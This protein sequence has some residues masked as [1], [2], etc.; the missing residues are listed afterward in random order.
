MGVA[1]IKTATLFYKPHSKVIPNF[2]GAQTNAWIIFPYDA[3]KMI[4]VLGKK[5]F[6][7]G[8]QK[9]EIKSRFKKLNFLPALIN[10]YSHSVVPG[11]LE[12]KS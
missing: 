6:D 12:V 11:G 7:Q 10:F 2:Y 5:W 4:K 1:H 8:I 3:V 9:K